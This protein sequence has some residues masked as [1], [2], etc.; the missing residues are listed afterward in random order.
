MY[1]LKGILY[2]QG[3][4]LDGHLFELGPIT[5]TKIKEV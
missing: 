3:V 2:L 1:I 4:G 5:F